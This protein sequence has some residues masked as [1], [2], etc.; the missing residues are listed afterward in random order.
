MAEFNPVLPGQEA[1][2]AVGALS[3][4]IEAVTQPGRAFQHLGSDIE[5]SV[6]FIHRRKAQEEVSNVYSDIADA[7]ARWSDEVNQGLASGNFDMDKFKDGYQQDVGKIG[8]NLETPEGKNFFNRQQARLQGTLL[9][10]AAHVQA[11]IKGREANENFMD[12]VTQDSNTAMNNPEQFPDLID[13]SEE[14]MQSMVGTDGIAQTDLPKLR[15]KMQ[16][17]IAEGAAKGWAQ[18]E[19]PPNAD[20]TPGENPLLQLLK[21]RDENG[22]NVFDKYL[23]ADQQASLMKYAKQQDEGRYA[24]KERQIRL[25][26]QNFED[27][28]S[29]W[30][31]DALPALSTNQLSA[32]SVLAARQVLGPAKTL[33]YLH[34]IKQQAKQPTETN[35]HTYVHLA[36]GIQ[37]DEDEPNHVGSTKQIWQEVTNGNLSVAHANQLTA[38]FNR[39]KYAQDMKVEKNQAFKAAAEAIRFKAM[40]PDGSSSYADVGESNY[41]AFLQDAHRLENATDKAKGNLKSIYDPSNKEGVYGLVNKYRIQ[42][43]DQDRMQAEFIRK[44]AIQKSPVPKILPGETLDAYDKRTRGK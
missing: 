10:R 5:Q 39:T 22:Q 25:Q 32:K 18:R 7:R 20:G 24:E 13:G 6:D 19:A 36:T 33:E 21:Q 31:L 40:T 16:G 17:M 11:T 29:K 44:N 37:A 3:P 8:E 27:Q 28:A 34:L 12:G 41:A 43:Q 15:K 14:V 30:E 2:G 1:Q 38:E 9:Q 4:N 26:K 35:D 42:P 23:N